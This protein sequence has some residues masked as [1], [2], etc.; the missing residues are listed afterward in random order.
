MS[1]DVG[2]FIL[3]VCMAIATTWM[4][5]KFWDVFF[6]KKRKS[7]FSVSMSIIYFIFQ[8]FFEYNKGSIHLWITLLNAVMILLIVVSGYQSRGLLK[9]FLLLLFFAICSLIEM[10]VYLFVH[11]IFQ[12]GNLD[13]LGVMSKIMLLPVIY[14]LMFLWK[15][16]KAVVIPDRYYFLLFFIPFGSICITINEF[17]SKEYTIFSVLTISILLLFNVGIFE[18]YMKINEIFIREKERVA[19][20]Q[21][22]NLIS[23]S[24]AEQRKMMEDIREEKHNFINKI[25][26]LKNAVENCNDKSLVKTLYQM[27]NGSGDGD[28]ISDSGNSIVDAIINFK[29]AVA[30]EYGIH[31]CLNLFIPEILPIDECDLGVVIG[32][33]IDNAIEAARECRIQERRIGISM[34][35]KKGAWI[36]RVKN[37]YE[38]TLK[39]DKYGNFLS[40]K[41]DSGTHGFGI[42]SI[43]KIA[44]CYDGECIVKDE[45]GSF[46]LIVMMNLREF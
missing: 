3:N 43:E 24:L 28:I 45:D 25:I 16:K 30:K 41:E 46:S 27:I 33:A 15:K 2:Q 21:Q 1:N 36:M 37:P 12:E 4:V 38:H 8:I 34:G 29:Y 11:T 35:V 39:Q 42:R 14:I 40:T 6:E 19:Y 32:N 9:F 7:V 20:I 23:K 10:M 31:F 22:V 18:L 5:C 17:Y 44:A 26:A 13:I